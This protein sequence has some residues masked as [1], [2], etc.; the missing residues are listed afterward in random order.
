[1]LGM[2]NSTSF[3]CVVISLAGSIQRDERRIFDLRKPKS[4]LGWLLVANG[5]SSNGNDSGRGHR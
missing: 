3:Q 4:L 2:M 5:S 1:M